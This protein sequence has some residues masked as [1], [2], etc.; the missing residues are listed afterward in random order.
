VDP[1]RLLAAE[2]V[3]GALAGYSGVVRAVVSDSES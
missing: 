1:D 3:D 2:L